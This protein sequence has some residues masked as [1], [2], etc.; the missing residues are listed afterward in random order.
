MKTYVASRT[1]HA[2]MWREMRAAGSR[3]ISTWIDEAGQGETGD[4]SELWTRV[5]DEVSRCD[6]LVLFA[7]PG[8]FPLKGA[9]VEVGVALGLGK[10]VILCLHEVC[11]P[12]GS[13]MRHPLVTRDD[14][15]WRVLSS[16]VFCPVCGSRHVGLTDD[17]TCECL[18]RLYVTRDEDGDH[19]LVG[20]ARHEVRA[21]PGAPVYVARMLAAPV[22]DDSILAREH[23][24]MKTEDERRESRANFTSD[25][26]AQESE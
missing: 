5:V 4:L 15:V 21:V 18:A 12:V 23:G 17:V 11:W 8:D 26:P 13:W 14:D 10:P 9:L 25:R 19:V 2:Q 20:Y 24:S 7:Q 3:V 1:R 6:R 16:D 22:Y